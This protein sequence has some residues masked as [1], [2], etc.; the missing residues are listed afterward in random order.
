MSSRDRA[1]AIHT[2]YLAQCASAYHHFTTIEEVTKT[3]VTYLNPG[4]SLL[5]TDLVHGESTHEIFP[6]DVHHIVAHKGGFT[7]EDIRSTFEKA[8]L[9]NITFEIVA[10]GTHAGH[11]VDLFLARG[12]K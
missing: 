8:E 7:E 12:D 2:P 4:G 5:V 6:E 11:S 9:K 1:R 3:L 10:Q